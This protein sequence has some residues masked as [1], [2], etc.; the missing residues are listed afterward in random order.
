LATLC[1]LAADVPLPDAMRE[2]VHQ[3]EGRLGKE[4]SEAQAARLMTA[5]YVLAGIRV[6]EP[7]LSEIFRGVKIMLDSSA[8]TV[9]EEK[10]RKEGEKV[11]LKKGRVEECQ[12]LLLR[13]GE[14]RFGPPDAE[15]NAALQTIS[16]LD[17]LERLADAV[18]TAKSWQEFLA[19]P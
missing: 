6:Q 5:T 11:G 3:I 10:G 15:T 19:T 14:A 18:L 7:T 9:F 4:A 2:V 16:D 12:R 17:R 8:F 13:Q 1:R